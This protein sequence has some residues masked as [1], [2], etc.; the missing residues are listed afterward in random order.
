[1]LSSWFRYLMNRLGL[2]SHKTTPLHQLPDLTRLSDAII[3]TLVRGP[4]LRVLQRPACAAKLL[5]A[6]YP[7][8]VATLALGRNCI[9]AGIDDDSMN[10]GR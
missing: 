6:R 7:R 4:Q 9:N 10:P 8:F 5:D 2:V 3:K 1:M